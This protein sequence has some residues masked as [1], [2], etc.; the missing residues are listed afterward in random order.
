MRAPGVA[1]RR[2]STSPVN[3]NWPEVV[4]AELHLEAVTRPAVRERHHA[5]VV[6]RARR[7]AS[8][9]RARARRARRTTSR[10]ARSSASTSTAARGC[11]ARMRAS[12]SRPSRGSRQ[13]SDDPRALA[14]EC[15]RGFVAEPAVARRSRGSSCRSD[16]GCLLRS[17]L[18]P[19]RGPLARASIRHD[20]EREGSGDRT[21]WPIFEEQR[22]NLVTNLRDSGD[23]R[24]GANSIDRRAHA[25]W[26]N[27]P[28][29]RESTEMDPS[30]S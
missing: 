18:S 1:S 17:S 25:P 28:A 14:G 8:S 11:A 16:R 2:S 6:A 5:G 19:W 30:D 9:R 4:R 3:A 7:G 12:A 26:G 29:R 22:R 20:R 21:V 24:V 13:A 15:E 10:L 23:R 27:A